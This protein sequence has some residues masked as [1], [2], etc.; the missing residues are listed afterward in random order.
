MNAWHMAMAV[1]GDPLSKFALKTEG[2]KGDNK[3]LV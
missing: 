1:N 3:D 2:A